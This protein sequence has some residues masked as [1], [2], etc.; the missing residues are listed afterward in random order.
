MSIGE[1]STFGVLERHFLEIKIVKI[2]I[3]ISLLEKVRSIQNN[4]SLSTIN[5]EESRQIIER[6]DFD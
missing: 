5:H 3:V 6:D 1:G 2:K 4:S